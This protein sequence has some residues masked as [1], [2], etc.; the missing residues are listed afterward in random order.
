[1]LRKCCLKNSP[2]YGVMPHLLLLGGVLG[3]NEN[4]A[5]GT[6][7]EAIRQGGGMRLAKLL[8]YKC[9]GRDSNPHEVTLKGF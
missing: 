1:V 5:R 7:G 6:F 3:K 8:P 4:S 2:R 9:P